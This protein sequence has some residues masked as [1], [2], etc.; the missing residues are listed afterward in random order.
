[1]YGLYKAVE[2]L[3]NNSILGDFVECGV[4]KGGSAMLMAATLKKLGSKARDIWLYDTFEGMSQ[5]SEKDANYE[6]AEAGHL[7]KKTRK[8]ASDSVWCYSPLKDV[9]DNMQKTGYPPNHLKLVQ[10]KIEDTVPS[11]LPSG[12]IALLRLDTDWYESTLH[13]MKHFFP[14][15]VRGGVLIVDDYGHWMGAKRAIDEYLAETQ[16]ALLLNALDYTGRIAVKI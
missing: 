15:L 4:W 1:M 2:Y 9:E 11:N 14:L 10:G 6:G 3:V 12:P 8:D 7:L 13:E 16:T 5:P